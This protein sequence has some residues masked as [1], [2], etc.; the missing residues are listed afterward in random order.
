[1]I[2]VAVE[3]VKEKGINFTDKAIEAGAK[4]ILCHKRFQENTEKEDYYFNYKN[5]KLSCVK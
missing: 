1:M 5:I 2:F 3:G 4:V